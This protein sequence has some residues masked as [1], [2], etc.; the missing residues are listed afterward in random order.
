MD[1]QLLKKLSSVLDEWNEFSK[2]NNIG[3]IYTSYVKDLADK[4]ILSKSDDRIDHIVRFINNVKSSHED[5]TQIAKSK[6]R[7]IEINGELKL[8]EIS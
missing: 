6:V 8:R 7:V 5:K 4:V 3:K 2:R 1:K